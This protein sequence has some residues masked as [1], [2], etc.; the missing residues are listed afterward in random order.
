M[1]CFPSR[2]W[3]NW[4]KRNDVPVSTR[5]ALS[6]IQDHCIYILCNWRLIVC[7]V[8]AKPLL[9]C[10]RAFFILFFIMVLLI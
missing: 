6:R 2:Y 8:V 1:L 4:S 3:H 9:V 5:K 7:R 10:L